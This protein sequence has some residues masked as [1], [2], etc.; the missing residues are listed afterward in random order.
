M[1][2]IDW[3]FHAGCAGSVSRHNRLIVQLFRDINLIN[4]PVL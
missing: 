1:I 4:Q 2:F 3:L